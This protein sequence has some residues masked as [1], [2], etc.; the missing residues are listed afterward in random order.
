MFATIKRLIYGIPPGPVTEASRR[1]PAKRPISDPSIA[2]FLPESL[3]PEN[4]IQ[5]VADD[6]SSW[7]EWRTDQSG[8]QWYRRLSYVDAQPEIHGIDHETNF[9]QADEPID[10]PEQVDDEP[11]DEL[12]PDWQYRET[13]LM[14]MKHKMRA[15]EEAQFASDEDCDDDNDK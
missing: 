11:F 15:I 3:V 8:Q 13:K 5:G 12:D 7:M 1:Q 9:N 14:F 10:E 2:L 6:G 4:G